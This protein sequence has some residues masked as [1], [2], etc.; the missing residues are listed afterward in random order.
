M[1]A[2][3]VLRKVDAYCERCQEVAS[4]K[5]NDDDPGMCICLTCGAEQQMMVP[6]DS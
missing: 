6:L 2:H 4:F 3:E 1:E 5:V